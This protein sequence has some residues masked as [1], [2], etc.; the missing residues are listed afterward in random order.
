MP[1]SLAKGQRVSLE[2]V[3]PGLAEIFVGLGW[4]T[5]VTDGGDD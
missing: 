3:A 5:K 2:K 4:D 1:L